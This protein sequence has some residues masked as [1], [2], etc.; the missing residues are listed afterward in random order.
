MSWLGVSIHKS[1]IKGGHWKPRRRQPHL[2]DSGV[3]FLM[4]GLPEKRVYARQK[5]I[6]TAV[7]ARGVNKERRGGSC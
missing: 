1:G 4:H 3:E 5:K 6:A 2:A 7:P